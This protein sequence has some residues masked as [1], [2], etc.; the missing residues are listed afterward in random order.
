MAQHS[1]KF[2]PDAGVAQGVNLVINTGSTFKDGFTIT[3][4][5]GSAFD[6][7]GWSG[8][9]QMA[10]SVAVGATLGANR[11]FNVGFTSAAGGK[12]DVSLAATQ[13]TDL[14]AG[15]YVWNL[16]LTGDTETESVLTTAI[17]AGSTAG[18]GTTAFTINSK[19]NVAVG[20]S[21][22]FSSVKDAPV[23]GIS[24]N[25]NV[26]EVGAANTI[27]S[28][29]MPGTAVTFTRAGTAS[30][31]YDVASGTILVVAGISSS[32]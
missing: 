31:I 29:V 8:S 19:S 3:R 1:F 23:V 6:L 12:F 30:T 15:R 10:K 14:S 2:D 17:S 32:P 11:T 28:K 4:P 27:S 20:D 24:T 25:T 18:I 21:V 13:T 26:I 22:T 7:T 16:L 9:S 5:N